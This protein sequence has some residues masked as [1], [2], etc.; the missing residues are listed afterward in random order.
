MV[1]VLNLKPRPKK[2]I[3]VC[4]NMAKKIRDGR[5]EK[6]FINCF[7][8]KYTRSFTKK[9]ICLTEP[10]QIIFTNKVSPNNFWVSWFHVGSVG[11]QETNIYIF[12]A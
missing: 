8:L 12:K 2:N 6:F 4:C 3:F 9:L 11:L 5:L 10:L 7:T 1:P